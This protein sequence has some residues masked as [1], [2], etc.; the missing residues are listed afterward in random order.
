MDIENRLIDALKKNRADYAEIRFETEEKTSLAYRG[1]EVEAAGVSSYAGGM[2]RACVNG[3]WG[4]VFF[5]SLDD[6]PAR[7]EEARQCAALVGKETTQLAEVPPVSREIRAEFENDFRGV[8]LDEKLKL[9]D[10]YN[11]II[12]NRDPAIETSQVSYGD[13]MRTVWFANSRGT[14]FM[15]ERPRVLLSLAAVARDGSLVQRARDGV[16]SATDYRVVLGLENR[17]EEIADRSVKLLKAPKCDGGPRTVILD[18]KLGGVFVHEA[19]GHLSE[20]DF[21]YENPKVRE[22]M[23][24]GREI[25]VKEL[26]VVDEGALL[27]RGTGTLTFDDEGTPTGK[28]YLIKDGVLNAHLHSLETAAKMGE[29]PTGNARAINRSAA[30]VVRMTNTYIEPGDV[31]KEDLFKDVEDGVY[32]RSFLGGQTMMEMF[33]FSA[34]YGHRIVNGEVGDLVRDVVLTGNVFETLNRID[35]IGDDLRMVASPGGCGKAGQ[36]PLPVGFGSP[37]VRIRDLVIGGQ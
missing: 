11:Q 7:L 29:S 36:A 3:G 24:V 16:D 10:A 37:H 6:L 9:L 17:I 33:T 20:A 15:E 18:H 23:T 25:G 34:S 1:E 31:K 27:P 14:F 4:M 35:A 2:V 21:L 26:N 8:P 12:L 19:F 32:A 13:A 22:L 28:T 5:D 30:P